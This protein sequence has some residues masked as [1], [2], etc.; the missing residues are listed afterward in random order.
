[1]RTTQQLSA[2]VLRAPV[3]LAP[4]LLAATLLSAG[5]SSSPTNPGGAGLFGDTSGLDAFGGMF[6]DTGLLTD[7]GGAGQPDGSGSGGDGLAEGDIGAGGGRVNPGSA[8]EWDDAPLAGEP[9]AACATNA[10]CNSG[11]CIDGPDGKLCTVQCIDC[12][13]AGYAC[14]EWGQAGDSSFICK[15]QLTALCYPCTE[16]AECAAINESALC[17]DH[18]PAGAPAGTRFCAGACNVDTDCP[19]DHLCLDAQ[20]TQGSGKQC[21]RTVGSCACSDKAQLA[22]ATASCTVSNE[23][24]ACAGTRTCAAEGLTACDA[25]TP[26]AE[27]CNTQDDDCDGQTDEDVGGQPCTLTNGFGTCEGVTACTEGQLACD[28]SVPAEEACNGLDDDC[29]GLTDEGYLDEDGNGVPDCLDKDKDGDGV[30]NEDDCAPLDP[31]AFPGNPE[32]CDGVDNDCDG[33]TDGVDLPGCVVY[34]VDIDKDGFGVNTGQLCLCAA[35]GDHAATKGNDCNDN[36]AT[37]HPDKAEICGNGKDDNCS[38]T[39]DEDGA[40]GCVTYFLDNDKDGFGVGQAVCSCS[41]K[42]GLTATQGGDCN[43]SNPDVNPGKA[44]QCNGG[45]DDCDGLA[46]EE[47]AQ[48][49][50]LYYVDADADGYGDSVKGGK[51]LCSPAAGYSVTTGGDCD[52][53][54][55]SKGPGGGEQC[56]GADDDCDGAVDEADAQGCTNWYVDADKDGFGDPGQVQCLCASKVPYTV[57][58]GGDCNDGS[59][60]AKPGLPEACDGLDNNCDGTTDEGFGANQPCTVGQGVC[61]ANGFTVCSAN[62]GGIVCN[63]QEGPKGVEI[64]ND[65]DDDCDGLTDE[66]CDDDNDGACDEA[67]VTVGS[68][69]TC[70]KGGGDCNDNNPSV[71]PGA[72]ESCNNIDDDCNGV[73]DGNTKSCDNGC[74]SGQQLCSNGSWGGC[75]AKA[76]ECTSGACCDGCEFRPSSY[77]CGNSPVDTKYT[78]SDGCGGKVNKEEKYNYCTGNSAS[79]GSSNQKWKSAGTVETCSSG[80]LCQVSGNSYSCKTCGSSCDD[81]KDVCIDQPTYTICI[82]PGYGGAEPGPVHYGIAS[83]DITWDVAKHLETWLNQ[84]TGKSGGG[85]WKVV[86]TRTQSSNP[87]LTQRAATCNNNGADRVLAL[88]LNACCGN[89][90]S[91]VESYHTG[92]AN[93]TAKTFTTLV[94]NAVVSATGLKNRGVKVTN[95]TILTASNAPGTSTFMGFLDNAT[96][97]SKVDSSGERKEIAKQLLHAI[98]QSFGYSAFTP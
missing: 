59:A 56:N 32:V 57:A 55:A 95:W 24:G 26:A 1:M 85:T 3:L 37:I 86:L 72:G 40:A 42:E 65:L 91:G 52:D 78:C 75:D 97:K 46:D 80:Q 25:A 61:A 29:D 14:E 38:G 83:K 39:A 22:G 28:A 94:N 96:D 93:D 12:C 81:A 36:D 19:V 53:N 87:S 7:G 21:V 11:A 8:C 60:S 77:Q 30:L 63:A 43:D 47:D 15:P 54:N 34:Y 89:S 16:D 48:G 44:E 70:S 79:C 2:P 88:R 69:S 98:Q 18:G 23:F 10:D 58:A 68:P 35:T 73:V 27:T 90:A 49:C 84:D 45:D 6:G 82:D 5:C 67:M 33:N 17:V 4:A 64:C 76:P 71:Y 74:N 9:G 62:G 41:A 50:T 20:G 13:P 66:G 51:C 31:K 92:S